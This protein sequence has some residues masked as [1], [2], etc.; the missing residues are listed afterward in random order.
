MAKAKTIKK[1]QIKDDLSILFPDIEID[2]YTIRPWTFGNISDLAPEI[3][4]LRTA[5]KNA[6]LDI[7]IDNIDL[8]AD[9]IAQIS[10]LILP[11]APQI[12]AKTTGKLVSEV[13]ELE[14]DKALIILL[15]IIEQNIN[16]LKNCFGSVMTAMNKAPKTAN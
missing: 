9:L 2:G 3:G 11:V 6:D 12:I 4:Y 10:E 15:K 1:D 13:R 7:D 5:F 8:N 14:P 16:Y